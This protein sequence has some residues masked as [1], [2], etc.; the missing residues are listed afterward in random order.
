MFYQHLFD[1]VREPA[2]V[3]A[4]LIGVGQFGTPMVTQSPLVPRLDV[5]IVAVLDVDAGRRAFRQAGVAEDDI[6]VCECRAAA[7]RALEAGKKVVLQDALLMMDLPLH[8][9]ATATR[10]PEAGAR[11]AWEAIRHGKHVV[12]VDKEADS[13]VGPV[14]KHLADR[15]G[16]VFTTDDGDQPG[17]LMGLVSWVQ[18]LGMEVLC[19][20]N[21]HG[22]L[23]DPVSSTLT[24]RARITVHVPETDRWALEPI[25]PGQAGKYVQARRR[26]VAEWRPSQVRG[27]PIC[28]MA[29]AANGTGL[30]PDAPVG[31]RPVVRLV[32]LPEVLCPI[33]E[34][35]ILGVRGAMDIPVVMHTPDEPSVDGGVYVVV[36]NDDA[37]SRAVMIQ[38]GL[39]A[40]SGKTSMLIYRPHHFC[41][42]ETAMSILCAG[43]LGVPTGSAEVLPR[44]DMVATADRDL[45]AGEVLG[46]PGGLGYSPDLRAALAPAFSLAPGGPVPYF[47]LQGRR[48]VADV[49]QGMPVTLDQIERPVDSALWELREQQDAQLL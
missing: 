49:P 48:L 6:A 36:A 38:K 45:E 18:S 5:P 28:H 19:G 39:V 1:R 40:N 29:V 12:M 13:V 26:L 23:Y 42:A 41:G 11:Y 47:M 10:S 44:I 21:L 35:G 16:V 2:V 3:R 27:D 9:I 22:C 7:L 33:D 14:L 31:H 37:C 46:V 24:N 15:A 20:G 34:G 4:G 32:E 17:L 25:P 30:L 8:V 43:L